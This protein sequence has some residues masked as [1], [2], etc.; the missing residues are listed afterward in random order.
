MSDS[1]TWPYEEF[2]PL[3]EEEGAAYYEDRRARYREASPQTSS[4]DSSSESSNETDDFAAFNF[5]EEERDP[6]NWDYVDPEGMATRITNSV[7]SQLS[8]LPLDE[9]AR[10][11]R[12]E[13]ASWL[14]QTQHRLISSSITYP[15]QDYTPEETEI[16]VEDEYDDT[17]VSSSDSSEEILDD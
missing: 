12:E 7:M 9:R 3:L 1:N 10:L 6:R 11:A 14:G 4:D 8:H 2:S 13:V 16:P 15:A 5:D 17:S